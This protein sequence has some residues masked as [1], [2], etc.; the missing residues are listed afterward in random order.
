MLEIEGERMVDGP[1]ERVFDA[2]TDPDVVAAAIPIIRSHREV[3]EDHWEA[4]VKAPLPFAPSVTIRFQVV[5]R[6]RPE[7]AAILSDGRGA[8]V[9]SSFD[10]AP[11]GDK[12]TRVLWRARI[13]LTGFLA[14]FGGHG[15]E[16]L[17]RR[18]ADRVL[19]RV[20]AHA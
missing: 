13:E 9:Q 2:L 1:P 17:A 18:A 12:R 10:L 11:D 3:D 5:E 14:P 20:A 6:R 8:H 15:L 4:K 16:P 19:D 7:H